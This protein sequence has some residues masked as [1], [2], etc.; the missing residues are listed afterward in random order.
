MSLTR[1]TL[2]SS[3]ATGAPV[4][5]LEQGKDQAGL[6]GWFVRVSCSFL[7]CR[8][9]LWKC[10][11]INL[12]FVNLF[13]EQKYGGEKNPKKTGHMK[14][15]VNGKFSMSTQGLCHSKILHLNQNGTLWFFCQWLD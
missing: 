15:Q 7:P 13:L 5:L 12:G 3:V 10:E 9:H 4:V 11:I 2:V 8:F 1:L 14:L 6:G